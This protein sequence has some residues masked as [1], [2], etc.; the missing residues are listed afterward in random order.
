VWLGTCPPHEA[1]DVKEFS[2]DAAALDPRWAIDEQFQWE[3]GL[4][5]W[6]ASLLAMTRRHA[7]WTID[8][9]KV[10]DNCTG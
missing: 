5:R 3:Y 10:C 4:V 2:P 9:N 7:E 6:L 1:G 8:A